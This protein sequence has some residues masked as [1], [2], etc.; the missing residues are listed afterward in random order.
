LHLQHGDRRLWFSGIRRDAAMQPQPP[1]HT[2]RTAQ[3]HLFVFL[4]PLVGSLGE[5]RLGRL[6]IMIPPCHVSSRAD[7]WRPLLLFSFPFNLSL[8]LVLR[9]MFFTACSRQ[10]TTPTTPDRPNC[11]D[12][13]FPPTPT[14]QLDAATTGPRRRK[15][16]GEPH[17]DRGRLVRWGESTTKAHANTTSPGLV[18][19]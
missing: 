12:D 6:V 1:R 2:P 3:H 14:A 15:R 4:I 10:P 19:R 7:T 11:D 13:L 9:M 5:T 17:L 16:D 8:F 18:S